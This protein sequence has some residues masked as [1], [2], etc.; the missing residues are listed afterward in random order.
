MD[1]KEL[2]RKS[3]MGDKQAQDECTEKGIVLPCPCCKSDAEL[4]TETAN[5]TG[6]PERD[7]CVVRCKSCFLKTGL[8]KTQR[9]VLHKWNARPAPPI[10]RCGECKYC[11]GVGKN[12]A[13]RCTLNSLGIELGLSF[14]ISESFCS[15]F[16]PRE[17]SR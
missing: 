11:A 7:Y 14:I 13:L 4:I 17:E 16:E 9:D 10:G 12:Q 1:N 5:F 3:L 6:E 2:I 15:N 8:Y